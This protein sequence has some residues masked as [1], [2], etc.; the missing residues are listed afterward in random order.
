MLRTLRAI[1]TFNTEFQTKVSFRVIRNMIS[2]E[3][4]FDHVARKRVAGTGV[5]SV[6][7]IVIRTSSALSIVR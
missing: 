6:K 4:V 7:I 3:V 5:S 1:L 2:N